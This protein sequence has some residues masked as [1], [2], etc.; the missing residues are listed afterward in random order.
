[1]KQ[2]HVVHLTAAERDQLAGLIAQVT[3]PARELAHARILL[4]ADRS[5]P[6]PG[7]VDERAEVVEISQPAVARRVWK[8]P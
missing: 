1:M 8:R 4:K 3:E 6:G 2:I 5:P 7:W